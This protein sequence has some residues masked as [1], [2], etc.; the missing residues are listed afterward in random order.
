MA[1]QCVRSKR[2]CDGCGSCREGESSCL[3]CALCGAELRR[4]S[5]YYELDGAAICSECIRLSCRIA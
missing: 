2:E 3:F 4:G 5:S 1:Y